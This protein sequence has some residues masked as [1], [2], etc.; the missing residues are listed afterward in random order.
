MLCS[1]YATASAIPDVTVTTSGVGDNSTTP[2]SPHLRP[3]VVNGKDGENYSQE[4][5]N[6]VEFIYLFTFKEFRR[7]GEVKVQNAILTMLI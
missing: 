1:N 7:E 4:I 3:I 6:T 2:E 5:N